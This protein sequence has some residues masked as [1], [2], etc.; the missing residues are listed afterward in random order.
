MRA[1]EFAEL[2]GPAGPALGVLV[3]LLMAGLPL[4]A[5]WH[6]RRRIADLA[7]RIL[8]RRPGLAPGP[9]PPL[10]LHALLMVA[11]FA[12]SHALMRPVMT[13]GATNR[14][15]A[16]LWFSLIALSG[17][18]LGALAD[19]GRRGLAL[20]LL[21]AATRPGAAGAIALAQAP[22]AARLLQR[23]EC[24]EWFR[25]QLVHA[26]GGRDSLATV[27][28][29]RRVDRGDPR[30]R[31][32]RYKLQF[33]R[34]GLDD[35]RLLEAEQQ[36]HRGLD[37][38]AALHSLTSLGR[39]LG[40]QLDAAR[41]GARER[42]RLLDPAFLDELDTLPPVE[43]TAPL[44]G[45]GLAFES[46]RPGTAAAAAAAF[47]RRLANMLRGLRTPHA[48]RVA[49][50]Y[51]FRVGLNHDGYSDQARE[52]M[53]DPEQLDGLVLEAL[54]TGFGWGLR[55]RYLEPPT[56]LPDGLAAVGS[57]P[58]AYRAAFERGFTGAVLPAEAS[59]AR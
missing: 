2:P 47:R 53:P 13:T 17:I 54:Y 45:A 33:P 34:G 28:L 1:L 6:G 19:A 37:Q 23:G 39:L 12:V 22:P 24:Y 36:L 55:Q 30:F 56:S 42:P 50:G 15:M 5:A 41:P 7:L 44:H 51:G 9:L 46:P 35:P 32:L 38:E 21:A 59:A 20:A 52:L 26:S 14:H 11:L 4:L 10:L 40:A 31:N 49:E 58:P 3:A 16:P 8:R 48:A 57:V 18:G 43:R 25:A 27:N 29:I